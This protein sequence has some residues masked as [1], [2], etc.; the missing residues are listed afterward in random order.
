MTKPLGIIIFPDLNLSEIL[1]LAGLWVK[2]TYLPTLRLFILNDERR[3][4]INE[5][6][7]KILYGDYSRKQASTRKQTNPWQLVIWCE[8]NTVILQF[9]RNLTPL[10]LLILYFIEALQHVRIN[11]SNSDITSHNSYSRK[12]FIKGNHVFLQRTFL[13]Q[14]ETSKGKVKLYAKDSMVQ[15]CQPFVNGT[16]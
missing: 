11:S 1:L 10:I 16:N 15:K 8:E 6:L 12:T 13:T 5:C 4:K 2:I 14:R 3:H 9:R 7:G